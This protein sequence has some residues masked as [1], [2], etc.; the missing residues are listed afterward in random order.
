M[1][2]WF[3]SLTLSIC[4]L[5]GSAHAGDQTA[6]LFFRDAKNYLE[7]IAKIKKLPLDQ[8]LEVWRN[9]LV[10]YPETFFKEEIQYNLAQL[11]NVLGVKQ[12]TSKELTNTAI[13][14]KAQKYIATHKLSTKDQILLWQQF[15]MEHPDN[16]HN[17][18]VRGMI[19]Q[20][21]FSLQKK[22]SPSNTSNSASDR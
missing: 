7:A 17:E 9:F 8:Q 6:T 16:K 20:L 18:E 13:F 22:P 12:Q 19:S 10:Q 21:K 3:Y 5:I 4:L 1:M 15:L 14:L 2:R 11:E